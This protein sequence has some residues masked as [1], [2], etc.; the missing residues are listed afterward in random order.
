MEPRYRRGDDAGAM[1]A[2][3]PRTPSRT[4]ASAPGPLVARFIEENESEY[5]VGETHGV[6]TRWVA[7]QRFFAEPYTETQ[8]SATT[9]LLRW[10]TYAL[11]AALL[12]G[13]LGI[14]L[15]GLVALAVLIRLGRLSSQ[16]R[17]W[18]R[19]QRGAG[20]GGGVPVQAT[21]ERARLLAALG[22]SMLGVVLGC[23]VLLALFAFK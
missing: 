16:I 2:A 10:S 8:R 13:V 20:K 17:R 15:G 14:A 4:P 6:R 19:R 22:Q 21:M 11:V 3:P 12:G 9:R 1:R 7:K 18:R 5:L 23:L